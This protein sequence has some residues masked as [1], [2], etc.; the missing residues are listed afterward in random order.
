MKKYL[1]WWVTL[2]FVLAFAFDA[3]V[4]SAAVRIPDVGDKLMKS[5]HRQA[6]LANVYIAAGTPLVA[7]ASPVDAWGQQYF[8]SAASEGF[9]RIQEDSFVAVDLFFTED[10]NARHR[11]LKTMYWVPPVLAVLAIVLWIRRPKKI[12]LMGRR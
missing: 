5:V 7:V 3:I 12:S 2:L 10:W 1:H 11:T 8:Q 4:W 6:L 9:A